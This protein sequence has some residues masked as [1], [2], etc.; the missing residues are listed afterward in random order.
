MHLISHLLIGLRNKAGDAAVS[1]QELLEQLVV[2][3]EPLCLSQGRLAC[4][5][6]VNQQALEHLTRRK[7]ERKD[8]DVDTHTQGNTDVPLLPSYLYLPAHRVELHD[9]LR[10]VFVD[11]EGVDDGVDF[12]CHF[13][14]LAPVADLVEVVEVALPA[15]SSANQ[16]VGCLIETVTG[17]GQDVQTVT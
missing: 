14:L 6:P 11:V 2:D 4:V 17:D 8:E 5:L 9:L 16:L 15:L 7:R 12:E 10:H 1:L 3:D 13:I